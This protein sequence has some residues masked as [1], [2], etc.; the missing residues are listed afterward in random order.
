MNLD[1]IKKEFI[2]F[3]A[4]I[5]GRLILP[6]KYF[7]CMMAIFIEQKP[8]TQDRIN[9]LTGYSMTTISQMLNLIQMNNQLKKIKK[10]KIRKK[11]YTIAVPPQNFM[12]IFLKMIMDSYQNKVDFFLPLIEE[13]K[14]YVQEHVRFR[15]FHNYLKKF[16]EMSII[17]LKMISNTSDEFDNLIETGQ[18]SG[19]SLLEHTLLDSPQKLNL[20][21]DLIK[22]PPLPKSYLEYQFAPSFQQ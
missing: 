13:V 22:P 21:Q 1:N 7:G 11:S 12:L 3:M 15:N 16:Y 9:E 10:P 8:I 19:S 20:L 5:H 18:I 14:P 17:Y 2:Q 6:K 4:E